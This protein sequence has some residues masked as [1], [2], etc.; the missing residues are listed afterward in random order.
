[1]QTIKSC[2]TGIG[3]FLSGN[4]DESAG[5]SDYQPRC[6]LYGSENF[7]AQGLTG[8]LFSIAK[9]DYRRGG[10]EGM[11]KE[12]STKVLAKEATLWD[13]L[14]KTTPGKVCRK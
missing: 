13:R 2:T 8:L 10:E 3:I 6:E 9:S 5:N 11:K 1:L 12:L 4:G 7:N 14:K